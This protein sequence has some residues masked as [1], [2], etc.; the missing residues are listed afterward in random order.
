MERLDKSLYVCVSPILAEG[1][2]ASYSGYDYAAIG[3]LADKLILMAYDYDARDMRDFVGTTYY[4]TAATVPM[5]QVYLGL[6]LLTDRVESEKVLLG[7][8]AR[9]TAWQ[10]DGEGN[11]VSGTPVYPTAETVAARLAQPDTVTG[12]SDTYQQ[13]YAIYTT[14]DSGRYFLWY[15]DGASIQAELRCAKALGV[16]GVSLWRLGTLPT[17]ADWNWNSLLG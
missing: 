9:A 1:Y 5:D 7:F 8:S 17:S 14:E 11:L 10:I 12:W 2:D 4:R 3:D 6:K 16:T 15:Q 13:S